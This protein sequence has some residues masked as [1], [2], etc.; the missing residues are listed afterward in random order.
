MCCAA[1]AW[2]AGAARIRDRGLGTTAKCLRGAH[3]MDVHN[4]R[5]PAPNWAAP[6]LSQTQL[7]SSKSKSH[8]H[9]AAVLVVKLSILAQCGR[10]LLRQ[11]HQAAP[12][13]RRLQIRRRSAG[14]HQPLPRRDQL[15]S[16]ALHLDRR[17]QTRTRR[18]QS[19]EANVRVGPLTKECASAGLC[20]QW[21][22]ARTSRALG[23]AVFA[24]DD[25]MAGWRGG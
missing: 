11:A 24:G 3:Q 20:A 4:P 25:V 13:A 6:T 21:I 8:N 15:R 19:R 16:Q 9:C 5:K 1:N 2:T 18:C 23:P 17:S 12:Q 7:P 10:R 14:R 22:A